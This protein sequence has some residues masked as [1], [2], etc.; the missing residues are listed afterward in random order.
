MTEHQFDSADFIEIRS[1]DEIYNRTAYLADIDPATSEPKKIIASYQ[2][3]EPIPCGLKNCHQPHKQGYL[4]L[5]ASGSETNMGWV[6]GVNYFGINFRIMRKRFDRA[7][8][9]HRYKLRLQ[10]ILQ[11]ADDILNRWPPCA[12]Y[13]ALYIRPRMR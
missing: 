8:S 3:P 1:A 10:E 6:C 9:A 12:D 13:A 7:V 4:V 2:F 11:H 5:T